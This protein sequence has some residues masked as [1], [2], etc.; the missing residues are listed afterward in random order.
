MDI[1]RQLIKVSTSSGA[2]YEESQGSLTKPDIKTKISFSLKEMCESNYFLRIHSHLKPEDVEKNIYMV[3]ESLEL[4][5]ILA[6]IL[7]KLNILFLG[8]GTWNLGFGYFN[9]IDYLCN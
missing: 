1:K 2:N 3:N 5:R 8:L 6:S 7:N 4:K 9:Q